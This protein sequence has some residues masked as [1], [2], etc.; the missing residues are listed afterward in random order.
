MTELVRATYKTGVYIG[1]LIERQ[2]NQN[3]GLIKIIAVVKHP[4]QGDLHSPKQI[5]V[6]LFH[7]RKALA[8]F[9]KAWVPLTS[10]KPFEHDVVPEYKDSLKKAILQQKNTL[11]ADQ[12]DWAKMSL[13]KLRECEKEYNLP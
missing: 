9:E 12:S 7:Q 5:N 2:A 3:R 13:A 6:P 8:Q 11:Q 4:T 1:E 10:M